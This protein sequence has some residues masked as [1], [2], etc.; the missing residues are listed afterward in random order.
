MQ[1]RSAMCAIGSQETSRP[2]SGKAITSLT[3]LMVATMLA[4]VIWTPLGG[5]VVPLV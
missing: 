3:P 1:F 4:C 5:P 2:S